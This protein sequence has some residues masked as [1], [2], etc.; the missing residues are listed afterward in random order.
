MDYQDAR[1]ISLN[2]NVMQAE[3]IPW[4]EEVLANN[5]QK[6]TIVT[7]HHPLF[8][9]SEGREN[10]RL[11]EAWKPLFDKYQVDLPCRGTITATPGVG[12]LPVTM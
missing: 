7:Y 9:A 12:C 3:Q 5:P 8:S 11:R 1:I 2:S 4:L 6:W 10:T